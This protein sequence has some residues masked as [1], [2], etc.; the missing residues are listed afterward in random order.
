MKHYFWGKKILCA[1]LAF[2]LTF[3]ASAL[4]KVEGDTIVLGAA[5]SLSGKY[6]TNGNHTKNGYDLAAKRINEMGGVSV[7]GKSYQ[8][9][10]IYYDD[11]STPARA[12]QLAERLIQQDGVQFM[13]GPYSSGLTKAIAPITERYKIPMI[14]ANGASRSLFT[15]GYRYL[16][17]LLTSADQ[18]LASAVDLLAE[19]SA[20]LG[21]TP[22][23]MKLALAFENDNFSQDVRLG[24][25]EA[26]ER[27]GMEI[28][29]DDKLPKTLD[30]MSATLNKAKAAKPDGL[31]IS[32]HAKGAAT[33]ARQIEQF[34]VDVPMVAM[35]H[36][37]S[38]AIE[39][40][41]PAGA[42]YTL[43]A[44][45]WQKQ[46]TYKDDDGVFGGGEDFVRLFREAYDYEPPY[47]AAE[48]AAAVQ[49]WADAFRRAGSFDTEKLRD[50]IAAT[51][52]QT[53]YGNVKFDETGKNIAKPMVM[54]QIL[55]SDYKVVAP[56]EWATTKPVLPR[57]KWS[58]R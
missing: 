57:P 10:I 41:A 12:A 58:D 29:I 8:I 33:G 55:E 15:K 2:A 40:K 27:H 47:Q 39:S 19:K 3:G 52:M 30:D 6:S 43:C 26:A 13:L 20:V 14:E 31:F 22:G 54:S 21:K 48:S 28:V 50:T 18:Y 17:A 7:A 24:V 44:R 34:R 5:V 23:D 38:A 56:T 32:G 1:A 25:V 36:C 45:Q 42:E 37:D 4:A 51:Q 16:F 49:V 53:F 46:L 9:K 35:T 11:E